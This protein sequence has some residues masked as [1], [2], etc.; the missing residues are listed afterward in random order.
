MIYEIVLYK[1]GIHLY[2][3]SGSNIPLKSSV[4]EQCRL[5]GE[6]NTSMQ[7]RMYCVAAG[8]DRAHIFTSKAAAT[9]VSRQQD[10]P[11][12]EVYSAKYVCETM[13][14]ILTDSDTD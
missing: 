14:E 11:V 3:P 10:E 8:G 6:Y 13:P 7:K 5:Y 9:M 12:H 2:R 1:S 4:P